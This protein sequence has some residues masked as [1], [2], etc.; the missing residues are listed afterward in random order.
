VAGRVTL[1]LDELMRASGEIGWDG[2]ENRFSPAKVSDRF[3]PQERIMRF[4]AALGMHPEGREFLDWIF[5]MTCR[6]PY[7][8]TTGDMQELAF[9][10]AKHQARAAVGNVIALAVAE[11][12]RLNDIPTNP[13]A[14]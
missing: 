5:D 13:G 4:A 1:S 11:G 9:A 8:I 12:R 2:L 6:A 3:R 7:P 10:A 14:T